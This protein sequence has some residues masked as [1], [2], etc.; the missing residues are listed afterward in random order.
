MWRERASSAFRLIMWILFL[1]ALPVLLLS[2]VPLEPNSI[3]VN[4]ALYIM[5]VEVVLISLVL[6]VLLFRRFKRSRSSDEVVLDHEP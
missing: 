4:W 2:F 5:V 6:T 3:N 1:M